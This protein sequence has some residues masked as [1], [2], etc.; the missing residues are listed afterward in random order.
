M[1]DTN[2]ETAPWEDFDSAPEPGAPVPENDS[3]TPE[4]AT[5]VDEIAMEFVSFWNRLVSQT[6]W[7][8]GKVIHTWRTRLIE[9]GV[10]H[11]LYTD[12]AIAKRIGNVSGQHVGRLRRVFE[13]FESPDA[14]PTLYWSHFQAAL[15]WQDASEWLQK[16]ADEALS[17]AAMRIARWEK[18]GAPADRKPKDSE[19]VL[20]EPDED[21][22]PFNDSNSDESSTK[23]SGEKK[24][25]ENASTKTVRDPDASNPDPNSFAGDENQWQ[26]CGKTTADV[27][28]SLNKMPSLPD[29]LADAF[30]MLKLAIVSHKLTKWSDVP[31]EHILDYLNAMR[32]IVLSNDGK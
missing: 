27:L 29:D 14:Y 1:S 21:V 24:K 26:T 22:N 12:E 3:L 30:E 7:E 4:L 9:A 8:K 18:Y 6:N 2:S 15:D 28:N 16:A 19:I 23:G 10:P 31:A 25:N 5:S 13:Q 20:A 11:S 17:V 32:A